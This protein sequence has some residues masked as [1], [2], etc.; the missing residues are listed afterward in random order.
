LRRLRGAVRALDAYVNTHL[1]YDRADDVRLVNTVTLRCDSL[2]STLVHSAGRVVDRYR[3]HSAR[4]DT[5]EP[6][7]SS[8]GAD[9]LRGTVDSEVLL[10]ADLSRLLAGITTA[11][12]IISLA[13]T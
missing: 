1:H 5:Y 7:A 11:T 10:A 3:V 8:C 4:L 12:R 6:V 9:D 2:V 13:A